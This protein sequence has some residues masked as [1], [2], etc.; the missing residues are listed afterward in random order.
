MARRRWLKGSAHAI[1]LAVALVLGGAAEAAC[2][3]TP[4]VADDLGS[5]SPN[6][7]KAGAPPYVAGFGGFSC[8]T[9]PVATL[10]VGNY[11]KATVAPAAVL[12]LTSTTTSDSVNYTLS[13]TADGSAPLVPGTA[14]F[15]VSG[16]VLNVLGLLGSS[17]IN[18]PIYAKPSAATTISPGTYTGSVSIKW[19]WYFCSFVGALNACV[20]TLDSGSQNATITF[21]LVV[22]AKP[23]TIAIS[24]VTT[25]DPVSTTNS[26]KTIPASRRRTSL[27]V[28]NRDIVPLDLNTLRLALPTGARTI[29]A[30]D[31]DGTGSGSVVQTTQGTP[32]S[33]LTLA[34]TVPSNMADDVD[35]SSDGGISWGYVPVVG[36]LASEGAV[37]HVRFSPRGSMAASSSLS[38]SIPYLVK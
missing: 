33:G 9:I 25:W 12:K 27:T 3:V 37:T 17:P 1:A 6:A 16:T 36:D 8:S 11:L 30:L 28:T 21:T 15:Y 26:P 18:V 20:G 4:A 10:L 13:A 5:F 31:G 35:F 29:V 14:T 24:S 23:A 22:A 19:D 2:G 38:I 7:L 32:A 34:Y